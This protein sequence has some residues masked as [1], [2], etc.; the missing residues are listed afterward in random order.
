MPRS[1]PAVPVWVAALALLAPS[2]AQGQVVPD[3]CSLAGRLSIARASGRCLQLRSRP[4]PRS[5][6]APDSA[7]DPVGLQVL[8]LVL[9][10]GLRTAYP[11]DRNDGPVWSGRGWSAILTGGVTGRWG[12]V[13]VALQPSVFAVQNRAFPLPDTAVVGRS[14]LA[15]PWASGDLDWYLRAGSGTRGAV[16]LGD[17][18]VEVR[19]GYLRAGV[20]HER[21]R[22]GPARRYPLLFSGTAGGFPHLYLGTG[23]NLVTYL[24]TFSGEILWGRLDESDWFD[25]D[26]RNDLRL[27]SALQVRWVPELVPGLELSYALA[28][29]EP[30]PERRLAIGQFAQLITGDPADEDPARCGMP[31][32]TLAFRLALPGGG[33]EVYGEIGRGEGFLVPDPGVSETR[34]SRVYVV[35]FARTDTTASGATWRV[36]GEAVR[37]ALDLPQPGRTAPRGV[38]SPPRHGHTHRGQ[39]LGAYI[40]PG[41]NAQYLAFDRLDPAWN[42]GAFVERVRR[43]DDTYFRSLAGNYGFRGHDVEWTVG[44]RGGGWLDAPFLERL[45]GPLAAGAEAGVSRRKN[46]NFVGLRNQNWIFVREWNVWADVYLSW[47]PRLR[48]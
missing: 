32:G 1:R 40:G 13:H 46:R 48:P 11:V 9:A 41:S 25:A 2:P 17:S 37:Q 35:G 43:D 21:L 10:G 29:H 6:L 23:R 34:L 15:Y 39:L 18:F 33:L 47:D 8:P 3:I 4:L 19:A 16:G 20:S 5:P 42:W 45:I 22:W 14:R 38:P 24:G 12:P 27:L 36:S 7:A 26:P 31:M 30:L 28:R 44:V